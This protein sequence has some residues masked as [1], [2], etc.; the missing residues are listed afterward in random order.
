MSELDGIKSA[1]E[2]ICIA[3]TSQ[4]NTSKPI[5]KAMSAKEVKERF[6]IGTSSTLLEL[7]QTKGSPAY[8]IGR[9]WYVDEDDFK[10]FLIKNSEQYK[11]RRRYYG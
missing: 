8:K 6:R 2:N 1:L 4:T 10:K 3:L 9:S 5:N 11:V 7:F